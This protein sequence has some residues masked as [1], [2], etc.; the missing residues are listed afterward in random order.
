M[1]KPLVKP[2]ISIK[3]IL[4][5]LSNTIIIYTRHCVRQDNVTITDAWNGSPYYFLLNAY[6]FSI[7][8]K[9]K[10]LSDGFRRLMN[11]NK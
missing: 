5:Y 2:K 6:H 9:S 11:H 10:I 8:H 3:I 1:N 7:L 4:I